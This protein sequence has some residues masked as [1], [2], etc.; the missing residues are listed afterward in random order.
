MV[1]AVTEQDEIKETAVTSLMVTT[2]S[3]MEQKVP[4]NAPEVK[5][6]SVTQANTPANIPSISVQLQPSTT[7]QK[8]LPR[9]ISNSNLKLTVTSPKG[10]PPRLDETKHT[11]RSSSVGNAKESP[12]LLPV[13]KETPKSNTKAKLTEKMKDEAKQTIGEMFNKAISDAVDQVN[14]EKEI[15]VKQLVED[16]LLLVEQRENQTGWHT[17]EQAKEYVEKSVEV[18]AF[19]VE[20]KLNSLEE[21][22]QGPFSQQLITYPF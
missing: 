21:E 4:L 19:A 8:P 1:Q 12:F 3:T 18:A 14:T 22:S 20:E 15:V 11:R 13:T 7:D 5:A 2:A 6:A 16:M 9:S 17:F 10:T